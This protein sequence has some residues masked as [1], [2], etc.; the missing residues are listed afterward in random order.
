MESVFD[1]AQTRLRMTLSLLA[2][3]RIVA[4]VSRSDVAC[5]QPLAGEA[6]ECSAVSEGRIRGAAIEPSAASRAS[7]KQARLC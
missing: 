3:V 5:V 2:S 7:Q 6:V 4:G 1:R